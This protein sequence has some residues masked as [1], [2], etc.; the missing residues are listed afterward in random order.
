MLQ[1]LPILSQRAHRKQEKLN[2]L[3]PQKREPLLGLLHSVSAHLDL[4]EEAKPVK[5]LLEEFIRGSDVSR[6]GDFVAALFKALSSSKDRHAVSEAIIGVAPDLLESL[7]QLF[8]ELFG[9]VAPV[10]CSRIRGG[11]PEHSGFRCFACN[12]EPIKG[13]RFSC[14]EAKIDLCGECFID[15]GCVLSDQQ[16]FQCFFMPP[17]VQPDVKAWQDGHDWKEWWKEAHHLKGEWKRQKGKGKG[18]GKHGKGKW[19]HWWWPEPPGEASEEAS[20]SNAVYDPYTVD[21]SGAG[22]CRPPGLEAASHDHSWGG[23]WWPLWGGKGKGKHKGKEKGS[24]WASAFPWGPW[25]GN[26]VHYFDEQSANHAA[27]MAP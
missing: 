12:S 9:P 20:N 1:F 5:P 21:A 14:A 10:F 19:H 13:P 25:E 22:D 18:K 16:Q 27:A 17:G 23:L 26:H 6:F 24:E 3:G 8:P 4:V 15:Q 2:K 11:P 7:P